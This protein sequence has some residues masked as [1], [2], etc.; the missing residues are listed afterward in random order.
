MTAEWLRTLRTL[1]KDDVV[2][3]PYAQDDMQTL[4]RETGVSL[5]GSPLVPTPLPSWATGGSPHVRHAC[6]FCGVPIQKD[7]KYNVHFNHILTTPFVVACGK[8][9]D[10]IDD[11]QR[12]NGGPN[13]RLRGGR[14]NCR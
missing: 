8:C 5:P 9:D 11:P 14:V 7:E 10:K 12:K 6:S 13:T 3:I 1:R 4:R 2:S